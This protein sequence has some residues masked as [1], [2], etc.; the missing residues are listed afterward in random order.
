MSIEYS[1]SNTKKKKERQE[2]YFK[3][4]CGECISRYLSKEEINIMIEN[5]ENRKKGIAEREVTVEV[6]DF[7]YRAQADA[8]IEKLK[9]NG[10][11]DEFLAYDK[12]YQAYINK[13]LYA[14]KSTF[15][16]FPFSLLRYYN[17]VFLH[18]PPLAPW[19]KH[20]M[21][22]FTQDNAFD[23]FMLHYNRNK[24]RLYEEWKTLKQ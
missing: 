3:K 16:N 17:D 11:Y 12:D 5:T 9:T 10:I 23:W 24:E 21:S 4:Q 7:S 20:V 19:E 1:K 2:N 18:R 13:Y 8:L 14:I 22:F 6:T 15:Y